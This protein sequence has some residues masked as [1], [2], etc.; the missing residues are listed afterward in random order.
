MYDP[1]TAAN[2]C[3]DL[4][5]TA[6]PSRLRGPALPGPRRRRGTRMLVWHICG[7][8]KH[9]RGGRLSGFA[10]ASLDGNWENRWLQMINFLLVRDFCS[11]HVP[12]FSSK[13]LFLA[14]WKHHALRHSKSLSVTGINSSNQQQR[15][16]STPD[17]NTRR[18]WASR[19]QNK[20]DGGQILGS[21]HCGEAAKCLYRSQSQ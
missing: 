1:F 4:L 10:R 8:R 17:S 15:G 18:K 3:P 2:V 14:V 19:V 13:S 12:I 9:H 7:V 21:R 16:C 5:D 11:T 20:T 6:G